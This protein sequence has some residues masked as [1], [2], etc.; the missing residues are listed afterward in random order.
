MKNL[1]VGNL[2]HSATEAELRE[3]FAAHGQVDN[4]SIINDRETG[5]ARMRHHPPISMTR[6]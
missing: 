5:R 6:S 2:P 4:V 1:Y 3:L